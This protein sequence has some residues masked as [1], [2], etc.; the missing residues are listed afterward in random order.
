MK[1]LKIIKT[2]MENYAKP[3]LNQNMQKNYQLEIL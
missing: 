2:V 3:I 1:Y